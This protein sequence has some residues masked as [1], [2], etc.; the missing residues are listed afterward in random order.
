MQKIFKFKN[1][2]ILIEIIQ[3]II[4]TILMS[5]GVALFLVPNKLSSGGFTGIST[6]FYYLF[7][8]KVGTVVFLLNVPLFIF[9]YFKIGKDFFIKSIIGTI[10]LSIGINFFEKINPITTDKFLGCIFGGIINGIG[11]SL[12]LKSNGSTGGT[13]LVTGLV[14]SYSSKLKTSSII[15]IFDISVVALNVIVFRE[16]EIGLYSAI[17]IYMSTKMVDLIFEGTNFTKM[18]FIISNKNEEISDAIEQQIPRGTTGIYSKGM[19]SND[20]RMMLLCVVSRNEVIKIRQLVNKIDSK[21]FIIISNAREV[22]G[23]GFKKEKI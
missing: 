21:A 11:N 3:L 1:K 10:I 9:S 20:D 7:E 15:A 4:G 23:E 14:K 18:I 5:I 12:V 19:Y 2:I 13:E 22:F 16:I 8:W 17:A 6:I